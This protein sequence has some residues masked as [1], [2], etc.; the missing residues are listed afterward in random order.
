MSHA[1]SLRSRI[2]AAAAALG[3]LLAV[4][5]SG[6][7]S[8]EAAPVTTAVL[9]GN[10]TYVRIP[11]A[12]DSNG[13]PTG[14]DTNPADYQTLPARGVA[15][16]AYELDPNTAQWRAKQIGYT[17]SNGNYSF[18]VPAGDNYTVQVE[19][20][21]R[22]FG[23]YAISLVADPNGLSSTLPQAQRAH[24]FLRC[25]ADGT[26]ATSSAPIPSS[27]TIAGSNYTVNF[28]VN[29]TTSWMTG[30]TELKADGTSP[31]FASAGF[32]ASPTGSRVLAILD[33]VY[34]ISATYVNPTALTTPEPPLD[35]HYVMG[36][37]EPQGTFIQYDLHHWVQ[38]GPGG[39]DLAYDPNTGTDH[40][41]GSIQGASANDDAWDQSVLY[42]L[43]GRDILAR[44]L[45]AGTYA[46]APHALGPVGSPIDG[47][48]PDLA[49]EE[50]LPFAMAANLLQSPYL[51]D[52]D[53]TSALLSLKDIRDIS[54]VPA[55]NVGPYSPLSLAS[56]YWNLGLKANG[57]TAPGTATNWATIQPTAIARI[58]GLALPSG[59]SFYPAN[60]YSQLALLKNAKSSLE[61]VDLAA[62]FDD[63]TLNTITSPY[64]LPWPQPTTT[65]FGQTWT[66]ATV[67]TSGTT[68]VYNG[69]LSMASDQM[70]GGVYANA[71]YQEIAYLGVPQAYDQAYQMTLQTT[72][73]PL[74]AGATIEVV[75]FAGSNT[76]AYTFSGNSAS[77]LAFTL[78]GTGNTTTP[79]YYPIRVRLIS[80]STL[81]P[82]I[83]FTL[84][85]APAP[86][87][88]LRGPVLGN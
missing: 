33:S 18:A 64:N 19:S 55:A 73:N 31:A 27:T 46:T 56:L 42:V 23:L 49:L 50:G 63:T 41:F 6:K 44:D 28:A 4:G 37:S 11:V 53:G 48:S 68:Y 84:Q 17:D 67:G 71:S 57:I 34:A 87:G 54:S 88:T 13:M 39:L 47:L 22:P 85:L 58:F 1:P 81:Q 35:L 20:F 45:S 36:H 14:L 72:P 2:A 77:P 43:L 8:S 26:P 21:A 66:S 65:V 10:V 3:L 25:A 86:P 29:L 60:I 7:K 61:P 40:Y 74:P 70:V 9:Q 5:C 52:T 51:A 62:I 16:R 15:V 30:S 83:P 38:P 24:Y 78:A 59:G 32:E 12:K 75:V 69:T 76:Q 80:P 79:A 82:D